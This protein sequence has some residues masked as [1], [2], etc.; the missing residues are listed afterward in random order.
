[1]PPAARSSRARNAGPTRPNAT[2][3]RGV[4][5]PGT[6]VTR[7]W[8]LRPGHL[9]V[10]ALPGALDAAAGGVLGG[11]EE[12]GQLLVEEPGGAQARGR[13]GLLELPDPVLEPGVC[14]PQVRG[15][16]VEPLGRLTLLL[17]PFL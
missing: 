4:I 17:D 6:G 11:G 8:R 1:M 12:R 9:P 10:G 5:V 15:L 3:G 13:T 7:P 16:G 14:L 2:R